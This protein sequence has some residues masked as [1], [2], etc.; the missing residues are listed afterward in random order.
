MLLKMQLIFLHSTYYASFISFVLFIFSKWI[1]FHNNI[2]LTI[3]YILWKIPAHNRIF[4][5]YINTEETQWRE[6]SLGR[7]FVFYQIPE[8]LMKVWWCQIGVGND[9]VLLCYVILLFGL[10][11]HELIIYGQAIRLYHSLICRGCLKTAQYQQA[12]VW[13]SS[14]WLVCENLKKMCFNFILF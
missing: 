2:A 8:G 6:S 9:S 11:D 13:F 14:S 4:R 12:V 1:P 7:V 5:L 3:Q 10:L